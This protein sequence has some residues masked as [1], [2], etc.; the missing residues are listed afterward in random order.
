MAQAKAPSVTKVPSWCYNCVAGPDFMSVKVVDGVAT[1]IEPDFTAQDIH[2]AHGRVCVKA[3]GLVQKTYNPHRVLQPMKRTN[4]RKG[5]NEDPGFVPISWEEALDALAQK[6]NSIRASGLLDASGLPRLA[7]T[8]GH[9]GTPANY[10]G[11][12]PALLSAWGPVDYSFGSGQGV[13]CV[14]SEHLYGEFWHRGFTVASDTP[15][16]RYII[17]LG[18][19][20]E[21]TG[22]PC[23]VIRPADARVRGWQRV[24]V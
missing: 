12:L 5:R 24:R 10:M 9:G 21:A 11:T 3:Y 17:S 8:F 14:H 6:L 20:V 13:K 2:P 18:A 15:L 23:A 19:N 7:A 16:A 1:A 4:P 22:G